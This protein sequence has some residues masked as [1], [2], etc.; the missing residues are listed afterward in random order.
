[1]PGCGFSSLILYLA[2]KTNMWIPMKKFVIFFVVVCVAHFAVSGQETQPLL[3]TPDYS[4]FPDSIVQGNATVKALSPTELVSGNKTSVRMWSLS[5]DLSAYA[6]YRVGP[7]LEEALYNLSLEEMARCCEEGSSA[8]LV[9]CGGSPQL[10]YAFWLAGA[11]LMPEKAARG[12]AAWASALE[13]QP[14]NL[15]ADTLCPVSTDRMMWPA[16]AWEIYLATGDKA[17]LREIYPTA[18]RSVERDRERLYDPAMRLLRGGSS[19]TGSVQ[20]D[21]PEWMQPAEIGQSFSLLTNAVHYQALRSLAR[22][23]GQLGE[24]EAS[25]HYAD[26]ANALRRA[27][28]QW[29]WMPEKGYYGQ[30]LYGRHDLMLSSRAEALGEALCVLFDIADRSMQSLIVERLPVVSFGVPC[31]FPNIPGVESDYNNSIWP[32]IQ[33]YWMLAG[34]KTGN[35]WSVMHSVASI[36]RPAAL[37]LANPGRFV[38]EDGSFDRQDAG[39]NDIGGMSA[40]LAVVYRLLFGMRFEPDG[41]QFEPFVPVGMAGERTLSGFRYRNARLDIRLTGCGDQIRRFLLDGVPQKEA[42][43]P[44]DLSGRH[45]VVIELA[46]VR[47]RQHRFN[48]VGNRFAPT[49]PRARFENGMLSWTESVGADYYMIYRN[50]QWW[51]I[52][53]GEFLGIPLPPDAEGKY[54]VVGQTVDKVESFASEPVTVRPSEA[55]EKGER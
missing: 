48:F 3:T 38:A 35:D 23:A 16:V 6:H 41:L 8:S 44:G 10:N 24:K 17:W 14:R 46:D 34:A 25:D 2:T 9:L 15:E 51:T 19:M 36:Y 45:E 50:G 32:M 39:G 22:M 20:N 18:Q 27:I 26:Q 42:L 28:N 5:H 37:G 33:A 30:Y 40:N 49:M 7:L 55:V 54:Q 12:L 53:R 52:V 13:K 43:L 31:I 29:F 1:M 11:V 47:L 4:W 21:Y